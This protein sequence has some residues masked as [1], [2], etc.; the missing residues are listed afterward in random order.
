MTDIYFHTQAT[1][2]GSNG[3]IKHSSRLDQIEKRSGRTSGQIFPSI[4]IY[5]VL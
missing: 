2:F 3:K 5:F 1:N 4:V